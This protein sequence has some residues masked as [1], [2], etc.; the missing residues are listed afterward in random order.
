MTALVSS[1]RL[2]NCFLCPC[3]SVIVVFVVL[4]SLLKSLKHAN[5]V[6]F[7]DIFQTK[8]SLTLVFEYMV[9]GFSSDLFI[10]LLKEGNP[11]SFSVLHRI[12]QEYRMVSVAFCMLLTLILEIVLIPLVF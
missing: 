1:S 3:I 10:C 9:S 5:I 7:H 12:L 11:L 8:E 2:F 6:L 4:V